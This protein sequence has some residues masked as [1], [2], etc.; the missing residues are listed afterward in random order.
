MGSP[1]GYG[2]AE[3]KLIWQPSKELDATVTGS[4]K[5]QEDK[6]NNF[7]R[8]RPLAHI[9][10]REQSIMTLV[11]MCLTN[12]VETKQGDPSTDYKEVHEKGVVSYGNRL[13]C[14]YED[15]KAEHSYGATTTYSKYFTDYRKFLERPYHFPES[16]TSPA[17]AAPSTED[18]LAL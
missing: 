8:L 3:F 11:M 15:D 16:V 7:L 4:D 2:I 1:D 5:K 17:V 6:D 12:E 9:G 14:R 13:Y 18:D 10:I